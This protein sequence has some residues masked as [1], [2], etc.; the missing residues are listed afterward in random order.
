V[1]HSD[2]WRSYNGLVD[3]GYQKHLRVDHG[4]DEF[5]NATSHING[6]EGF[7]GIG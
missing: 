7:L 1:I 4:K 2:K 3:L 5:V 6:I